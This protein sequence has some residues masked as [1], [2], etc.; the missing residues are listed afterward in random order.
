MKHA[1][2]RGSEGPC[3]KFP[4]PI[5]APQESMGS[6]MCEVN[7]RGVSITGIEARN[8]TAIIRASLA[9]AELGGL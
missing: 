9:D 5:T 7:K 2:V 8:G 4:I 1:R 3:L 6:L